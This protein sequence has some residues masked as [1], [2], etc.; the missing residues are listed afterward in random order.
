MIVR[1]K[2]DNLMVTAPV[3]RSSLGRCADVHDS[4]LIGEHA[5]LATAERVYD[6]N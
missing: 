2:V 1:E 5:K 4:A 6:R 3:P